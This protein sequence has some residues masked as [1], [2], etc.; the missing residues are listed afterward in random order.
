MPPACELG[1][2]VERGQ[3]VAYMGDSGNAESTSPHLHFSITDPTITDPYGTHSA[4]RTRHWSQRLTRGTC[5][6]PR[7]RLRPPLRHPPSL[8]A[9]P[10]L[11]TAC[12]A[13]DGSQAFTDV[14]PANVHHAAVECLAGLGVTLG[15]GDGAYDPAG[16]VT[17]LQMASFTAR[18][19]EAG[20]VTLPES[21]PD[22]FDDDAGTVH[23]L[24][25]NQLAALDV[26]DGTGEVGRDFSGRVAMK[27]D[28]MAAW[29]ARAYALI[30]G[31]PLPTTTTDYFRDDAALHHADINRLA[32]A[33]IVQGTAP[34]TYSPRIGVRRDQMASYLARTL[35]AARA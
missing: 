13:D 23:E 34:G 27:R 1:S 19:L 22:A 7:Q 3:H 18:L 2:R 6:R 9:A 26:L 25:V 12:L 15:V 20:G 5:R 16:E 31:E 30:A 10:S 33:G 32:E 11:S 35:A 14:G 29:M 8:K 4:I 17:R 21:P 28:R 24:A